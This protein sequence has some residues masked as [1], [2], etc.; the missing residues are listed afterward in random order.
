[1][2]RIFTIII[3]LLSFLSISSSKTLFEMD[4]LYVFYT[5][6]AS[7]FVCY[8]PN[9]MQSLSD[10]TLKINWKKK[11]LVPKPQGWDATFDFALTMYNDNDTAG[12]FLLYPQKFIVTVLQFYPNK[13][14]GTAKS[15]VD[16]WVE[17]NDGDTTSVIFEY[18]ATEPLSVDEEIDKS[19]LIKTNI[20]SL[21]GI[22]LDTTVDKL[23]QF[24]K[25]VYFIEYVY[26]KRRIIKNVIN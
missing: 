19:N 3:V 9:K 1:M 13:I 23:S 11:Y 4:K 5:S 26:E 16:F 2:K 8:Y 25:G 14:M 17:G 15:Q 18:V 24:P 22:L 6:S 21:D 7:N 20:Y 12:S 10:D